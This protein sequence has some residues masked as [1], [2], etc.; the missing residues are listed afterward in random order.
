MKALARFLLVFSILLPVAAV[1]GETLSALDRTLEFEPPDGYCLLDRRDPY[2]DGIFN[3]FAELHRTSGAELLAIYTE[4]DELA[5]V[6]ARR[7]DHFVHYGMLL[8]LPSVDG[9]VGPVAGGTRQGYI[10]HVSAVMSQASGEPADAVAQVNQEIR[11]LGITLT[12]LSRPTIIGTD[13]NAFYAAYQSTLDSGGPPVR[14]ATISAH[15]M[16]AELPLINNLSAPA[17][18]E[19]VLDTLFGIQSALMADFVAANESPAQ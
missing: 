11:E 1:Q 8:V 14:V 2:Q 4:C 19:A 18:D 17:G 7:L 6:V 16:V 9:A 15:T 10:A 12:E 13:D 3:F 5:E